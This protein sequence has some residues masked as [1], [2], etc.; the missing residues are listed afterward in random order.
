LY[1]QDINTVTKKWTD[2]NL[3]LSKGDFQVPS[4]SDVTYEPAYFKRV[5]EPVPYDNDYVSKIKGTTPVAVKL[6]DKVEDG[7]LGAK[8]SALVRTKAA[9][10]GEAIS[11]L[12][13][14]KREVRNTT[15]SYLTAKEATNH[16]LEKTI[17]NYYP[18]SIAISGCSTGAIKEN[19][20]R[21][22]SYR[23]NHHFS[24]VTI[25]GDD[26]KRSI[27]GIPVYNTYQEEV[28]FSVDQNLSVRSKGLI[29]YSNLDDSTSNKKGRENYFSKE[30]T[31]PYATSYLLTAILSPDYVDRT[32]NGI[33]DDD[34]GTAVKFNYSKLDSTFKWRTPFAFGPDTANYNE[35][36]LSD[37][38]DDKANYVYGEKEIWY[39]HSIESKT[40][41][42]HFIT[43]DRLDALGV[44]NNHGAVRTSTK[45][46]LLK[47]IRLYSKSDLRMNGNDPSKTIP[48]KVVHFVY[49]YSICQGLP[50]SVGHT[51]KL[52][53][54]R[55]YFTFGL[56]Q[57]GRLN[58]YDFQY[59]NTYNFYNY[60]QYD[61]WGNFKDAIRNPGGLNNSEFPYTLQDT[62]WT[63]KFA[64]A[65]QLN[66][67]ILPSGGS[68]SINYESD[69]YAYVQ[70]K[71]ASEMCMLNGVGTSGDSLGLIKADYI[72]VNLPQTV[73]NDKELNEKYFEGIT[74]LYYKVF[75]DLDGKGHKEFVPGY[76]E[77]DPKV[78][79]HLVSAP[80]NIVQVKLKKIN[81][82]NPIAKSGW[83]FIRTNLPKYAYPRIR[84]S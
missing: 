28:S 17:K 22:G 15:F 75:L 20:S 11:V 62:T 72:Y 33:S 61:R 32:G 27:Y 37:A 58:P 83:Q 82:V 10:N 24:E 47:E 31:P 30:R 39:L 12:K 14:G 60:R 71:R 67:I 19:I 21:S 41:V 48:I 29:K 57:K 35:G 59:D 73:N 16:G 3:F 49:D 18:D 50:N 36:F 78:P 66:K 40:M 1:K 54:K 46:K 63:N 34:L 4:S 52:T 79:P 69:D 76:A 38:L 80:G 55:I 43:E 70:D 7:V 26:G 53:L 6:Q 84:Q 25:T 65:W 74:N 56:N 42:A 5:G 77:L 45:L 2:R 23:K 81:D 68:I 9:K 13:R 64:R 51:G 44:Q 8:A